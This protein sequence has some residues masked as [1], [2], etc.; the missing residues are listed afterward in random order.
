MKTNASVLAPLRKYMTQVVKRTSCNTTSHLFSIGTSRLW[1][2]SVAFWTIFLSKL[3]VILYVWQKSGEK[4]II[5][6]GEPLA[7]SCWQMKKTTSRNC[8]ELSCFTFSEV[9]TFGKLRRMPFSFLWFQFV[10]KTHSVAMKLT[11]Q[12]RKMSFNWP[13]RQRLAVL[14]Y[15]I[16]NKVL[17]CFYR[18]KKQYLLFRTGHWFLP[19]GKKKSRKQD[20]PLKHIKYI[21]F[22]Y[23]KHHIH[24]T[25]PI[26]K[27]QRWYSERKL[28]L[29]ICLW[30][31][32]L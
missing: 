25:A 15:K 11:I 2:R 9:S 22:S 23:I 12:I 21:H 4:R 3:Y 29:M 20:S 1:N 10:W 5:R 16:E 6:K 8:H 30:S 24:T 14:G 28:D 13:E 19:E 17:F 31:A 32:Q 27:T 18:W 26:V 7:I